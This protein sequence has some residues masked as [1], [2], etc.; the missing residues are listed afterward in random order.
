M[1]M[2]TNT[3]RRRTVGLICG[4]LVMLLGLNAA[5]AQDNILTPEIAVGLKQVRT[6]LGD[7]GNLSL[8]AK[9]AMGGVPVGDVRAPLFPAST[10]AVGQ[11]NGPNYWRWAVYL[12]WVEC[13]PVSLFC[14]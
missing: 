12:S 4:G 2:F 11:P 8:K 9:L 3:H 14:V 1:D 13:I 7:G 10:E 5:K 6:I